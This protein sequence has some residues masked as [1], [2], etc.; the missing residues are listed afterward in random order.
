MEKR[1]GFPDLRRCVHAQ[2]TEILRRYGPV[3]AIWF[4]P[5]MVCYH[6]SDLFPIEEAY[7]LVRS[8]QP[9]TLVCAKQGANG[10]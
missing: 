7:A 4:D 5:I 2:L 1:P 6:R 9:H 8:L 10:T 3:A